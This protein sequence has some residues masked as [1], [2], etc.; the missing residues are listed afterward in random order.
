LRKSL[1][2][3]R[4]TK[5]RYVSRLFSYYINRYIISLKNDD[6]KEEDNQFDE[7]GEMNKFI[8]NEMVDFMG[9]ILFEASLLLATDKAVDY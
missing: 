6:L 8:I 5:L 1:R 3:L 7:E 9:G 4:I 2:A